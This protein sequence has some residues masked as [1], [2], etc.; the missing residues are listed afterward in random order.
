[1]Q[2]VKRAWPYF[3]SMGQF[4]TSATGWLLVA[5]L[6]FIVP[7]RHDLAVV[8]GRD[9]G[10][11]LDNCKHL[12]V[13]MQQ[14]TDL[15]VESHFLAR[16]AALAGALRELGASSVPLGSLRAAWLWLRAGTIVV[17]SVDWMLGWRFAGSRGASVV[18]MWHGIPLK[19][20]QLASFRERH[21]KRPAVLRWGLRLQVA[22]TGRFARTAWFV[23][24]SE[25]VTRHAFHDSFKY[26]R[27]SHAG[28]PRND[29]LFDNATKLRQI[30]VDARVREEVVWHRKAGASVGVYAPTF[31][32]AFN[33][34]FADGTIRLDELSRAAVTMKLL[35]LVKLHPWMQGRLRST[36]M[37]GLVF[38]APESD[39]YPLLPLA[40][41]LITDYSSIYFD[42]LLLDRPV[43]FFAY[44][45]DRYLAEER[46]MYFE[47]D[48]MTP[49]QKVATTSELVDAIR[50]LVGGADDWRNER[51]R[52]RALVFQ[53][54]DGHAA[55][56]LLDEL[57]RSPP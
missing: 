25:Y 43:L 32:Q 30:N 55:D 17:D 18:Q 3:L 9:G 15:G 10:K 36:D 38:V 22:V 2:L 45:L 48:E 26:Q 7:R 29:A 37:P 40:D 53:N 16:D 4:L 47:Y 12:F 31:R 20:V 46:S 49:G 28:Y 56:R 24:T 21:Q 34:P 39:L 27:V 6:T 19:R 5:P 35:L 33:D 13:R 42:F 54:E 11:F 57:F 51:A 52:V 8:L 14:R 23:S 50:R 44:D 41:F 1:M